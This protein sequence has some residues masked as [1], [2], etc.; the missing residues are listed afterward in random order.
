VWQVLCDFDGA[1]AS[2]NVTDR[3]LERF[4]MD[5]W[6]AIAA[7]WHADRI[8]S[9]ECMT[10]QM[11][12]VR[13]TEAEFDAYLDQVAIDPS[14]PGFAAAC[15]AA[16]FPLVVLS[17][18]IDYAVRR[19]LARHGA[20]DL[21]VVANRLEM[22]GGNRF[23]LSFP[24]ANATCLKTAGICRCKVAEDRARR[25]R[26]SLLIGTGRSDMCLA[27]RA[28]LVLAKDPL[29]AFCRGDDIPVVAFDDFSH[30]TFLLQG[31]TGSPA[32]M[33][34]AACLD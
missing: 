1:V 25:R 7:D 22:Y 31:L 33:G 19:I 20:G 5:G 14:F 15:R 4:A 28:D 11:D 16:R 34:S 26:L 29:L 12:L 13:A 27:G 9:R 32:W 23:R 2:D 8:G 18:G 17:D 3:L 24:Y 30:A 6:Q 10:R 21:P